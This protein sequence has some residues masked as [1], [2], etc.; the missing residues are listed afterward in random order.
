MEFASGSMLPR[1]TSF[2]PPA[3]G[4]GIVKD[5]ALCVNV[6]VGGKDRW[7]AQVRHRE[8]VV[9]QGHDYVV[10]FEAWASRNTNLAVIACSGLHTRCRRS[11]C[12]LPTS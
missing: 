6:T 2:S 3:A 8:M 11:A 5:G 7:D 12:P 1:L 9:Q 10:G 4:E